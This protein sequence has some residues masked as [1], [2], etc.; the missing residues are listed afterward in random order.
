MHTVL[1]QALARYRTTSAAEASLAAPYGQLLAALLTGEG[2]EEAVTA[3]LQ[4]AEPLLA[5]SQ[6]GAWET[7]YVPVYLEAV[8]EVVLALTLG[9]LE[10]APRYLPTPA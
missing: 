1:A 4:V 6:S 10:E 9:T 3:Y 5:S 8:Q 2:T 7:S